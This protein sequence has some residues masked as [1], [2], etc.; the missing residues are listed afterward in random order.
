MHPLLSH[1]AKEWDYLIGSDQ[2]GPT[3]RVRMGPIPPKYNCY[4]QMGRGGVNVR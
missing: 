4:Y 2:P 1:V 3:P